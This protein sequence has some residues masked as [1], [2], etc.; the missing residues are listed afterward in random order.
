MDGKGGCGIRDRAWSSSIEALA[1]SMW[2]GGK[3]IAS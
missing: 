1:A 2:P 3:T